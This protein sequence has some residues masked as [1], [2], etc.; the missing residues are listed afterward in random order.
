MI[1]VPLLLLVKGCRGLI[2]ESSLALQNHAKSK[3]CAGNAISIA[4]E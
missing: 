1:T 3:V 2:S 4:A